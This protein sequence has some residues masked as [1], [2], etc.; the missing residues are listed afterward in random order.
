MGSTLTKLDGNPGEIRTHVHTLQTAADNMRAAAKGVER[1]SKLAEY[2]SGSVGA[3]NDRAK[4]IRRALEIAADRYSSAASALSSW[5]QALDAAQTRAG[6]AIRSYEAASI[7]LQSAQNDL[8]VARDEARDRSLTDQDSSAVQYQLSSTS[9]RVDQAQSKLAAAQNEYKQAECDR[10]LAARRA[11]ER[12]ARSN[13]RTNDT[14]RD[15]IDAVVG[16]VLQFAVEVLE[17]FSRIML[18]VLAV[19]ALVAVVV[20]GAFP[21]L[22]GASAFAAG[23]LTVLTYAGAAAGVM[24]LARWLRGEVDGK[25]A[26]TEVGFALAGAAGRAG[27]GI[28][29]FASG[30]KTTTNSMQR[31]LDIAKNK[32]ID[33]GNLS[34]SKVRKEA[35]EYHERIRVDSVI[36]LGQ[37]GVAKPMMERWN[38]SPHEL[39]TTIREQQPSQ[40]SLPSG[41]P[42]QPDRS[43]APPIEYFRFSY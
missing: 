24:A 41:W 21:E 26:L 10:D 3:A 23:V 13:G 34:P 32:S 4:D 18:G 33:G 42:P 30:A 40:L 16:S 9:A 29:K 39:P 20:A 43:T 19:A 5:A 17:T 37:S 28:K 15:K 1:L 22:L 2:T 36:E 35:A 38:R 7:E 12:I 11:A 27:Q 31:G 25:S 14:I 8:A 6:G